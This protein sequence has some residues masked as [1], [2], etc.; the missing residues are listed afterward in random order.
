[1]QKYLVA[2]ALVLGLSSAAWAATES[3][4]FVTVDTVGNCSV[5]QGKPSAGQTAM[6]ETGGYETIEAAKQALDQVRNDAD[7]CKGVVE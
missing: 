3:K 5:A 1:M 4:W 7:K 6:L 2:G